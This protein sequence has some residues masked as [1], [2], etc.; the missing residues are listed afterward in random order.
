[1]TAAVFVVLLVALGAVATITAIRSDP[2][3]PRHRLDGDLIQERWD[4]RRTDRWT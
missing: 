2:P 4:R 1:V 3:P